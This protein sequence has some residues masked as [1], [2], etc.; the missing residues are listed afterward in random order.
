MFR[1]EPINVTENR[2]VLHTA[3]RAPESQQVVV[4][5][6]DVVPEVHAVLKRMAAFSRQVR[7]GEWLGHTGKRIRMGLLHLEPNG[8]I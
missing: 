1:G 6:V 5:G 4:D 7:S 2:A 8:K 3:L